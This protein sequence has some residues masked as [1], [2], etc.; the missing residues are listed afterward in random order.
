VIPGPKR[1]R[2][3][4]TMRVRADDLQG[5]SGDLYGVERLRRL[6]PHRFVA[7]VTPVPLTNVPRCY[8]A[9]ARLIISS[10]A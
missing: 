8:R 5:D 1:A 4:S 7:D 3:L 2:D 10:S 6:H 9:N